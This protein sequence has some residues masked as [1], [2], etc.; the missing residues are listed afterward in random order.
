VE[1]G[2]GRDSAMVFPTEICLERFWMHE[3]WINCKDVTVLRHWN[4]GNRMG[5]TIPQIGSL[6]LVKWCK[7][8]RIPSKQLPRSHGLVRLSQNI[9]PF[10]GIGLPTLLHSMGILIKLIEVYSTH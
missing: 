6:R 7:A 9:R 5:V 3:T 4:D 2:P 1:V 10:Y 8:R